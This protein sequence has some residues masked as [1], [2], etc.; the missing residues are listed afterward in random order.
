MFSIFMQQND[1]DSHFQYRFE[2]LD[3]SNYFLQW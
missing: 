1:Y 3:G 2:D